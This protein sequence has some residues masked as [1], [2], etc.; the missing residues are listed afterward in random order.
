MLANI[1]SKVKRKGSNVEVFS[2]EILICLFVYGKKK[3]KDKY[4]ITYT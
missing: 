4:L 2:N 1:Y 3:Y